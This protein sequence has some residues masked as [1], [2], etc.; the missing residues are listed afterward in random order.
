MLGLVLARP[1]AFLLWRVWYWRVQPALKL[2][3]IIPGVFLSIIFLVNINKI[4]VDFEQSI[5]FKVANSNM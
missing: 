1:N 2:K 4:L 5:N 3:R